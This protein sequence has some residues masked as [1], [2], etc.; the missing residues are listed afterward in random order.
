[1]SNLAITAASVTRGTGGTSATDICG[2]TVTAGQAVYK[3]AS[4]LMQ[5]ADADVNAIK[6]AVTGI[7]LHASLSG[8][9]LTYQTGGPINIGATVAVGTVYVLSATAGGI[10]PSTDLATGMY[11]SIIGIGTSATQITMGINNSGV[12]VP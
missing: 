7:A 9:P 11:T 10:C 2:A 8:Q 12:Q 6:A 1:M 4:N 3:D 5:L